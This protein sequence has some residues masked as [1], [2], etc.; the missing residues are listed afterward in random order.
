MFW[1]RVLALV[2]LVAIVGCGTQG[3]V[4]VDPV[5]RT[6]AEEIKSGLESLAETGHFAP[7]METIADQ[8][9][10]L[11]T[12]DAEKGEALQK[13]WEEIEKL[14]DPEAIKAKAKEMIEKL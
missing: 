2:A 8:I 1:T 5:E 9:A 10:A 14:T 6:P 7:G 11:K 4:S 3:S 13:D 12:T